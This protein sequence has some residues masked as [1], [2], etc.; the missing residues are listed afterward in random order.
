MYLFPSAHLSVF[1]YQ[2]QQRIAAK[3]VTNSTSES[4]LNGDYLKQRGNK[5]GEEQG[6]IGL[7][8]L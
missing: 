1:S 7:V 3:T 8:L 6:S 4:L 5:T 2:T